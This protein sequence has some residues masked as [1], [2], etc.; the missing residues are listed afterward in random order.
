M[1]GG[2]RPGLVG[3]TRT[4]LNRSERGSLHVNRGW[5]LDQGQEL[6]SGEGS[7]SEQVFTGF[8]WSHVNRETR[9]KTLPSANFFRTESHV[10]AYTL[11]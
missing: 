3:P 1:D 10:I 7:P 9:L 5:G 4:S 8:K 2:L 6:T 11:W